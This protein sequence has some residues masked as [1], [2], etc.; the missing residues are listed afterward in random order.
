MTASSPKSLEMYAGADA[1]A[2]IRDAGLTRGMISVIA[3]AAG[4]PKWLALHGLDR[5]VFFQWLKKVSGPV[6]LIG[7]SIAAWRFSALC[8]KGAD[9]AYETFREEYIHQHYDGKPTA[10]EV[11][12]ESFRILDRFLPDA[13]SSG[14]LENRRFRLNLFAVRSRGLCAFEGA[15]LAAGLV[16]AAAMNIASR[17]GMRLH[18][19][20]TLFRDSR[21]L[22]FLAGTD[23]FP[24]IE[25][26]L[27]AE[28]LKQS[29]LASGSIPL[30]M[31][32]VTGI[33]GAPPGVYRDG[34]LLDYHLDIP[35]RVAP[36]RVVLFPH[37]A[38]RII[39]GWF[40]KRIWWHRPGSDNMKRVLM[41]S[42]SRS[43]IER[44]PLKKIPDRDD[45]VKFFRRD[46]ERID[47]WNAVVSESRKLGE[48]FLEAVES[49]S[50][51]RLVKPL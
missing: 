7:S 24:R 27:G 40:D 25:V 35:Y 10:R 49:G 16:A 15:P 8:R 5:A 31:S 30:V 32:G 34:G 47:Y 12:A 6:H 46:G 48:E 37:Y 36:D 33:P 19:Q 11:T 22:P 2:M 18:F 38:D 13:A 28:N 14:I 9:S 17:R 50:I 4:G 43:F 23:V 44:L 42:P 20:R 3:G 45:F 1:L 21:S 39:P 51:R 41:L 26:A 29:I